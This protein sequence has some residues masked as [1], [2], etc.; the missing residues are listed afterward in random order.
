MQKSTENMLRTW[1]QGPSLYQ[2]GACP[3]VLL[4]FELE[5]HT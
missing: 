1:F 2:G 5:F 4:Q 3:L